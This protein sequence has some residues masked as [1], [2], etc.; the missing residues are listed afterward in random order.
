MTMDHVLQRLRR[1]VPDARI[2]VAHGRMPVSELA[3]VMKAFTAGRFDILLSTTIIE[4]GTDIPRAN[5]IMIDRADRFGMADLYQ[6]RGRVGRSD[7]RGYAY[8]LIPPHGHMDSAAQS[9][10]QAIRG[11]SALSIGFKLALRD[12]EIRG[13]GN[14]LGAEQSGHINAVGF[15]LY[16]QL[17]RRAVAELKGEP[18]PPLVQAEVTLDFVRFTSEPAAAGNSAV[19]PCACIED[20][21]LRVDIYRRVAA[22]ASEAEVNALRAELA[23][24]FGPLP[25]PMER[26]LKIAALRSA[27]GA[28][29]VNSLETRAG[30]VMIRRNGEYMMRGARFPRLSS[31][32]ADRRLDELA[33]MLKALK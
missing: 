24:R 5:T 17:L 12:L 14:L 26:L 23:D 2:A 19:I 29:G 6:L 33:S 15:G 9:R 18:A 32:D 13:A 31:S 8:L 16:C 30:K 7:R 25:A 3:E 27:C 4:S 20:E 22:A 11:Y 28:K 10:I 1:V 21:R